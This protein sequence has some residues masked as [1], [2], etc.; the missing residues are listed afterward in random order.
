MS[1][2]R[3]KIFVDGREHFFK[4]A[5]TILSDDNIDRGIYS[6][7]TVFDL[8][9]LVLYLYGRNGAIEKLYKY[10][11]NRPQTVKELNELIILKE[12]FDTET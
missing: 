4:E 6:A 12:W 2:K 8:R 10:T 11:L 3:I 5:M 1:D 9:D 7:Q